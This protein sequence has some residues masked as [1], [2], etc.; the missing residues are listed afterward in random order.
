M[1]DFFLSYTSHDRGWAEWIAWILEEAGYTVVIQAWDFKAGED[2][3]R[4]MN[5]ALRET[6][7]VIAVL[8]QEYFEAKYTNAEW[9]AAFAKDPDGRERL[10]LPILIRRCQLPPLLEARI[11]VDLVGLGE[12]DATAMIIRAADESHGRP[13]SRPGFPG[14]GVRMASDTEN[15]KAVAKPYPGKPGARISPDLGRKF[16]PDLG[17][18]VSKSCDRDEQEEAF[19][20]V[21]REGV[22][23]RRGCPQMY[24]V[25]GPARERHSSLVE[26][27]CE[28]LIQEY[29][30]HL[31]GLF[32][33]AVSFWEIEKWPTSGKVETDL[34]RVLE[35]LFRK[36]DPTYVFERDDYTPQAFH[37]LLLPM[38]RQVIVVQHEIDAEKFTPDTPQLIEQYVKFWETF[39]ARADGPQFVIF[40]NVEY[41]ASRS[42]NRWKIWDAAKRLRRARENRQI[43]GALGQISNLRYQRTTDCDDIYCFYTFLKELP[44]VK[45]KDV[46]AWFK[47]YRLGTNEVAWETQSRNIFRLKGWKFNEG[48]NMADIEDAL[49]EF[50]AAMADQVASTSRVGAN[51]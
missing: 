51:E 3:V 6:R 13:V 34:V 4:L 12:E 40:L 43:A 26:R 20:K 18:I 46:E 36:C 25:H 19:D 23:R 14:A 10:L 45:L 9:R 7:K 24:I 41:P 39:K 48:K 27:W 37:E 49:D 1:K 50:I 30:N 8:S 5:K 42:E 35:P 29:A 15:Y 21:F 17:P 38:R 11:S 31:S 22:K 32:T 47:K 28:T 33:A 16:R 2:F 44:S